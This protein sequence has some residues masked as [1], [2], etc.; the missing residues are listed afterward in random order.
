MFA[1]PAAE[2]KERESRGGGAGEPHFRC[3]FVVV[4]AGVVPRQVSMV[5]PFPLLPAAATA[6]AVQG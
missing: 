5:L 4:V 6:K 3:G 1:W 2:E